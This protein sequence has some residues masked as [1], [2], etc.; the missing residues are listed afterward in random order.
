MPTIDDTMRALPARFR[1]KMAGNMQA[2]IQFHFTGPDGGEWVLIIEGGKCTT[3]PGNAENPDA[4]VTMDAK[5]FVGINIG[6]ISAPDIFWSGQIHI[7]GDVEAVIGL[8]PV[9]EWR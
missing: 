4:T 5:D 8:A 7:Q 2:T 6:E 3:R 9:M 1:P